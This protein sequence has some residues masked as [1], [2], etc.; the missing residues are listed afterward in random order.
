MSRFDTFLKRLRAGEK[1][2]L[3]GAFGTELTRRGVNTDLP[4]WSAPANAENPD[5]VRAIHLDYLACGVDLI[6]TNTFRTNRRTLEKPGKGGAAEARAWTA[7]ACRLAQ[8][9][10][11][12]AGRDAV[13]IGGSMA[14]LEDCYQPAIVPPDEELFP[15]HAE[16]ARNL[17]DAGVDFLFIETINCI[18][19][20]VAC[21][22]GAAATGLPVTVS[23]VCKADGNL[24]SGESV[25]DAVD[26]VMPYK[27]V[28]IMTNCAPP[29]VIDA[30]VARLLKK[31]DVPVGVYAN[32]DGAPEDK[33]GWAFKDK[34]LSGAYAAWGEKWWKQGA[35]VVGACCGSNPEYIRKLDEVRKRLA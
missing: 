5:V 29:D 24:L 28:L 13:V 20:A 12:E 3:S 9:A 14:S 25:E 4:L 16:H 30:S 22:K 11:T 15:E 35:A 33:A 1:L 8:E 21:M 18:R 31:C 10:R 34:D 19:E 6:T 23:F 2:L 27:P 32:G 26:A 7:V 17:A